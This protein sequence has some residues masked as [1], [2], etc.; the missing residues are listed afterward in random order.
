MHGARINDGRV[1][2]AE[3]P[4]SHEFHRPVYCSRKG[5][6]TRCDPMPPAAQVRWISD[7]SSS[8]REGMK[9]NNDLRDT[10][11]TVS[12]RNEREPR[13]SVYSHESKVLGE[14]DSRPINESLG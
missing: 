12:R 5:G 14:G 7:G 1:N 9:V 8:R 13:A 4:S 11:S 2:Y 10:E 6:A 3:K